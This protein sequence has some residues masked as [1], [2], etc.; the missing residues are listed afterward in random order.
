MEGDVLVVSAMDGQE[1]ADRLVIVL[2]TEPEQQCFHG[3][4]VT[5]ETALAVATDVILEPDHADLPYRIAVTTAAA[6]WL[7]YRQVRRRVGVL[8]EEAL[9]AISAGRY[10]VEDEFQRS[11]RG[12]PLQDR[13]RDLRWPTLEAE[14]D[15]LRSLAEDCTSERLM[16]GVAPPYADPLLCTGSGR[17]FPDE[18]LSERAKHAS[19]G[20]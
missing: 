20:L 19:G 8:T 18:E 5:N 15:H 10:G 17:G 12:L 2:D 13:K 1:P 6:G 3:V 16:K 9:G 7:W 4:L 11:T 14:F